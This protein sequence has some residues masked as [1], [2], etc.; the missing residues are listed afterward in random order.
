MN[1]K[2]RGFSERLNKWVYG[3]LL[4]DCMIINGIAEVN[5]EYISIERWEQV[6]PS[7]VGQYAGLSD[8]QDTELYN[9]DICWDE[10]KERAGVVGFYEGKFGYLSENDYE[11]ICEINN[12]IEIIGNIHENKEL[13]EGE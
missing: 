9:G 7:S 10:I 11:D 13:L 3:Y 12:D 4:E 5:D 2:F 8:S 1:N 6:V